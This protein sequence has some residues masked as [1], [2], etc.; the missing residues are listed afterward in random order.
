MERS[1]QIVV[2]VGVSIPSNLEGLMIRMR[3]NGEILPIMLLL[4][5]LLPGGC[6]NDDGPPLLPLGTSPDISVAAN[7]LAGFS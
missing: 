1:E 2:S 3:R 4:A 6:Q 5:S 7:P